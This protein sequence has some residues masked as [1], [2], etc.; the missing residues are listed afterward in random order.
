MLR[1]RL[2]LY[3]LRTNNVA[4]TVRHEH[5]GRHKALFGL[6]RYV[7]CTEHNG[8]TDHWSEEADQRVPNHGRYGTVAP[9]GL[10][11]EDEPGYHRETAQDEQRDA[12][13]PDSRAEPA[14]ERDADSADEAKGE[15]E[16]DA[17]ERGVAESGDD[18]G[19]EA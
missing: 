19:P 12:D 18:Q 4:N 5:G 13:V 7:S 14:S 1:L 15:L 10:P 9:F 17:L 8:E 3:Q 2:A 6:A 16:E 11:Y